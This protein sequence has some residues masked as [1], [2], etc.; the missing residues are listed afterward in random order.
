[1]V[2]RLTADCACATIHVDGGDLMQGT[3]ES[4]L[5]SGTVAVESFNYIGLDAAAVGNHDL[6][7]GVDTL[8][9]RQREAR[10][11]RPSNRQARRSNGASRRSSRV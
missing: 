5:V 11:S 4:N 2:G 8:L 3:L 1:M 6:D 9:Q 7:W 10:S